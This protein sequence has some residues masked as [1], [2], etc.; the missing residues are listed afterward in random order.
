MTVEEK[1]LSE[2][3]DAN[4]INENFYGAYWESCDSFV[5]QNWNISIDLLS[6]KQ[7]NWLM[8]ILDECIEKRLS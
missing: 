1:F 8:K 5:L 2:G 4:F 3:I 6:E 7:I